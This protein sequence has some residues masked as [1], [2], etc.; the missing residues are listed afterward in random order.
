M[1][2]PMIYCPGRVGRLW[3]TWLAQHPDGRYVLHY[4]ATDAGPGDAIW[5]ATSHDG[6]TWQEDAA[7]LVTPAVG[8]AWLGSGSCWR[9]DDGRWAMS[10][11]AWLGSFTHGIRS[12]QQVLRF[13]VSD[14]LHTWHTLD[15][16]LAPDARWYATQLGESSRWDCL[17][18]VRTADGWYAWWT[19]SP[20]DG[21][22]SCG[23]GRSRDGLH[24]EILP[25][26][27]IHWGGAP[28]EPCL[29]VGGVHHQDGRWWMLAACFAGFRGR[30]G[31]ALLQAER[32]EGPWRVC[33]PPA[34]LMSRDLSSYFVR[35]A[36]TSSG[37]LASH[38]VLDRH[39]C[40]WLAPLKHVQVVDGRLRLG[41]WQGNE[42]LRGAALAC[43]GDSCAVVPG[44]VMLDLRL[45]GEARID[46]GGAAITCL[47]DRTTFRD[48]G[49]N[50]DDA[51]GGRDL[52]LLVH[53]ALVEAYRD[54]QL[55]NTWNLAAPLDGAIR[56]SG[57]VGGA[58]AWRLA[59]PA[60]PGAMAQP[61]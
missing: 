61:S 51:V 46:L 34:V 15:R 25:P 39:D 53:G 52:R 13:A 10:W 6:V 55:V 21:S 56:W 14:D 4:L 12:G 54:G 16:H 36:P 60:G 20:S 26:P 32:P 5:R 3:D 47:P 37:L 35:M 41:W 2:V 1:I 33:E 28:P 44:G 43:T 42:V 30:R 8:E 17:N 50:E 7:P 58:Q 18:P 24:W 11:S 45:V 23:F 29:E 40:R 38:Q 31:M 59:L 57:A 49:L 19:A 9:L 48:G 22:V 27:V